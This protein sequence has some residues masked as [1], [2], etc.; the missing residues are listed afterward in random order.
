M[1]DSTAEEVADFFAD[2]SS[3][4]EVQ[5]SYTGDLRE[6]LDFVE[7]EVINWIPKPGD[8]LAGT[9]FDVKEV[10]SDFHKDRGGRVPM[11][12]IK[13]PSGK[14]YGVRCYA[15]VLLKEVEF[16][17][18]KNRLSAGD[19]VAIKYVGKRPG[20]IGAEYDDWRFTS[21]KP[22]TDGNTLH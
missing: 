11:L 6:L 13:A 12:V 1:S 17:L 15:T 7:I 9:L 5:E 20:G 10:D 16:K 21:R 19:S 2:D 3:T 22:A 14:Y 8:V 4:T 18:S